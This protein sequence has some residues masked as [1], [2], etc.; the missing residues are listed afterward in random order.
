MEFLVSLPFLWLKKLCRTGTKMYTE[1]SAG[2]CLEFL[3]GADFLRDL[4]RQN[5]IHESYD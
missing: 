4:V 1:D 2:G 5:F 3:S